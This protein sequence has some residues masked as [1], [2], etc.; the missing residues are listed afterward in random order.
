MKIALVSPYSWAHPGGVN[1]HI[2]SLARKLL[3]RGHQVTV[4]APDEGDMPEGCGF[5]SAGRSI[6]VPANGSISRVAVFP[7]TAALTRSSVRGFD[8]VHVHEPL[9]PLVSTSAVTGADCRV[10]GTF[11]AAGEGR[12]FTYSMARAFLGKVHRRLDCLVAVSPSARDAASRYFPGCY[13]LIPNGVDLDVFSPEKRTPESFSSESG[14]VVLFVG[15]NEP[16]KGL[17]LLVDAFDRL[18]RELPACRLVLVGSGIEGSKEIKRAGSQAGKRIEVAGYVENA[19]LPSY[20]GAAD[21]FCAPAL[22]GESF[23]VV[24]L[25]SM[26]CGTPVVASD[27]P[28]YRYVV[29]RTGGGELFVTGDREDLAARLLELLSNRDRL[30]SLRRSGL[31]G[32]RQFSWDNVAGMLENCYGG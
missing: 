22:G 10:I 9:V 15:R 16:R 28:G 3:T 29:E 2:R 17:G 31:E 12:S 27:I 7:Q 20:Y 30:D 18:H 25:E 1:N 11:H 32:A 21:V 6:R 14:P 8:V 24:L 19:K 13:R 23:G 4:V 26:S 5:A